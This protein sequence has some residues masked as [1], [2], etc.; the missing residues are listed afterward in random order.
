MQLDINAPPSLHSVTGLTDL[1]VGLIKGLS[2]ILEI[3]LRQNLIGSMDIYNRITQVLL[4][5]NLN[6][7][8]WS[9]Q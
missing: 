7:P 3:S 9:E 8:N 5:L 6:R 1:C 4:P 2:V